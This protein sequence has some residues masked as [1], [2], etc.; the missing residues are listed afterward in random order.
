MRLTTT[1]TFTKELNKFFKANNIPY[2]AI[3]TPCNYSNCPIDYDSKTKQY[4]CITIHY[5]VEYYAI[6]QYLTTYDLNRVYQAGDT[7]E[8]Y[9]NRLM[10]YIAI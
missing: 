8:T 4:K 3:Y 9:F 6:P 2:T 1:K 10:D 5:P 7:I